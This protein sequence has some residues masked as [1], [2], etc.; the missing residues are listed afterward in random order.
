M[1]RHV[2][3]RKRFLDILSSLDTEIPASDSTAEQY[4][5]DGQRAFEASNCH[6]A[7]ELFSKSLAI[8]ATN[9]EVYM[10]RALACT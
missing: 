1:K 2:V 6:K 5:L 7:I 4:F 10:G 3:P 9:P 8:D